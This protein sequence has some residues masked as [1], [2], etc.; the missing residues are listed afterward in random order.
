MNDTLNAIFLLDVTDHYPI[1]TIAPINC[2]HKRIRVK[3][4]DHSRQNLAKLVIEVEHYVNNHVQINQD[5]SANTN[6]FC[7]N[8]FDIY[9]RSIITQSKK[10]KYILQDFA[11]NR[12][13]MLLWFR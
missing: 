1:F 10:K 11:S 6:N 2:P 5:V 7:N 8:L 12:I 4:R 3:F 9:N 13:L